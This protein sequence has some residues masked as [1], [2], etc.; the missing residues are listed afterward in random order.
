MKEEDIIL[1]VTQIGKKMNDFVKTIL[2]QKDGIPTRTDYPKP[3]KKDDFAGFINMYTTDAALMINWYQKVFGFEFTKYCYNLK[4]FRPLYYYVANNPQNM[5]WKINNINGII[6]HPAYSKEDCVINCSSSFLGFE[7][8][9]Y[10]GIR[11]EPIYTFEY[12]VSNIK[13]LLINL[14]KLGIYTENKTLDYTEQLIYK[15]HRSRHIVTDPRSNR[16]NL[17]DK[18]SSFRQNLITQQ[19]TQIINFFVVNS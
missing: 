10:N 9:N 14:K 11:R 7:W 3:E 1:R 16:I 15:Y 5:P 17:W 19:R 13:A 4:T 6:L 8:K 12:S 2:P 18:D